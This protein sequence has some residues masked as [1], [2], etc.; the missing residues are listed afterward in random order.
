M[1]I[2]AVADLVG[3]PGRR[4]GLEI[5]GQPRSAFRHFAQ[6]RS[7]VSMTLRCRRSIRPDRAPW[8]RIDE[9][10]NAASLRDVSQDLLHR[11]EVCVVQVSRKVP[12]IA[13]RVL[14]VPP[15]PNAAFATAGHGRR[16]GL[17]GGQSFREVLIARQR[18]GSRHRLPVRSTGSAYGREGRP[19]RRCGRAWRRTRR[20][21]SRSM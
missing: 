14:P 21:A 7:P 1:P 10:T 6:R 9:T 3:T 15:L 17:T 2:A 11:V 16:S 5:L 13:D 12:I 19:R 4:P 8:P 20:R 18:L